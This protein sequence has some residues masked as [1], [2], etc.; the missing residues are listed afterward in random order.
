MAATSQSFG[1]GL[2][3]VVCSYFAQEW[4]IPSHPLPHSILLIPLLSLLGTGGRWGWWYLRVSGWWQL[5]L[6]WH[7]WRARPQRWAFLLFLLTPPRWNK[8]KMVAYTNGHHLLLGIGI[9]PLIHSHPPENRLSASQAFKLSVL[10]P[11]LLA[12][13]LATG[14]VYIVRQSISD[15]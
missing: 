3:A 8:E 1:A 13:G 15:W 12:L 6:Y 11:D 9:S 10:Q 5:W 2:C 7:Y 4:S 14:F